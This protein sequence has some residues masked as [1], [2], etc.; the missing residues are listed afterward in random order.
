[1]NYLMKCILHNRGYDVDYF[2]N[3]NTEPHKE[4]KD[5]DK[6][7]AILKYYYDTNAHIVLLTD[8]DMDGLASGIEGYAG[9][10]ELGF[11][12]SLYL[13][14]IAEGYGF[15]GT[16]IDKIV[17]TYPDVKCI[18]TAD[19]GITCY[20]GVQR[21]REL[22]IDI[23][24]TDHHKVSGKLQANVVVDPSRPD[25]IEAFSGTCGAAVL[26][27]VLLYY[28]KH[29]ATAYKVS[30]IRRLCVFAGLGTVSDGMP[31]QYANRR[32]ILDALS[33]L[34]YMYNGD[35]PNASL[36]LPGCR[37]Y[38]S[39]FYGLY[40]L[41]HEM[42]ESGNYTLKTEPLEL[43]EDFI[44][45]YIAPLF[46]S[47]KRM[48]ADVRL[49]YGIFFDKNPGENVRELLQLNEDRKVLVREKWDELMSG[50]SPQPWAPYIYITDAKPGIRGLLAQKM[51]EVTGE[52]VLVVGQDG[53]GG[54][55]GSGRCP[56][57]YPF[58]D[59]AVSEY[60]Q[61][62]GH[63][64][65]FGI[66]FDDEYCAD[67]LVDFLKSSIPD[68]QKVVQ[69]IEWKPDFHMSMFD[70]GDV[71]LDIEMITAYLD[72]LPSMRPFGPGFPE[73]EGI[74][75]I[76]TNLCEFRTMG[77]QKEHLK[78]ILPMGIEVICWNQADLVK[79]H[80]VRIVPDPTEE[81]GHANPYYVSKDLPEMM[82]IVGKFQY[83]TYRG[84]TMVQFL[85]SV[86]E[87]EE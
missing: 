52:P 69:D 60:W 53:Q 82:R 23:L 76:N 59:V 73:P 57:W 74:L 12:T 34:A 37:E 32:L 1:M 40:V 5:T 3:I 31:V 19:T 14:V 72:E 47:I 27:Q 61:A 24:V 15:D 9:F 6:L 56:L 45:F 79:G 85:G 49:A 54:Y 62:D 28:A 70:T 25:D 11:N 77:G 17:E 22:G 84:L 58:L 10:A 78:I 83:S 68:Y 8:F 20:E 55:Y 41:L 16:T 26:Y 18:V 50:S 29:Y 44:G 75:D 64:P 67:M 81:E 33:I 36:S 51:L 65:A 80:L 21:A 86:Q 42:K 71:D 63:N 87:V 4:P 38:R 2:Q 35:N 7:C 46:N 48:D 66:S 13:P 43:N 39:A 30:Q